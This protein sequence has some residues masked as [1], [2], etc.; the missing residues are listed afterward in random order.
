MAAGFVGGVAG[1]LAA[2]W[3]VRL[4]DRIDRPL[5]R[6]TPGPGSSPAMSISFVGLIPGVESGRYGAGDRPVVDQIGAESAAVANLTRSLSSG[7][8]EQRIRSAAPGRR[9]AES[10]P[11]VGCPRLVSLARTHVGHGGERA[12]DL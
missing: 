10:S 11:C 6:V 1:D 12:D 5:S 7:T 4:A 9:H 8:S 2:R 3:R